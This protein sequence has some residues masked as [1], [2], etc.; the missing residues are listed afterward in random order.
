MKRILPLLAFA[1]SFIEVRSDD[2]WTGA[3]DGNWNTAGNWLDGSVPA[4]SQA[5][6]NTVTIGSAG[7]T[8]FTMNHNRASGNSI[9]GLIINGNATSDIVLGGNALGFGAGGID[10]S[11]STVDVTFN[12]IVNINAGGGIWNV[13]AGRMLTLVDVNNGSG[14]TT[15]G[16]GTIR[17]S[18]SA[19]NA[20][21]VM[22]VGGTTTLELAKASSPGNHT[23]GSAGTGLTV[24]SGASVRITG[25]GGEQIYS[26][27]DVTVNTGGTFDFNGQ[28]EGWDG[29]NGGGLI[30]NTAA[31]DVILTLGQNNA[32]GTFT[33]TLQ[34]SGA[35]NLSLVKTGSGTLVLNN[36]GAGQLYTGTTTINNGMLQIRNNTNLGAA[37]GTLYMNGGGIV[38]VS[39]VSFAIPATRPVEVGASGGFFRLASNNADI[40]LSAAVTGVGGLRVVND[41][42]GRSLFVTNPANSYSGNT[43]IGGNS[44]VFGWNGTTAAA[45]MRLDANE[46]IPHG[47]GKGNLVFDPGTEGAEIQ[48]AFL[49]LNGNRT[50]TVNGLSA[51]GAGNSFIQNNTAGAGLLIIGDNNATASFNGVIRNN[52]GSGG[53]MAI[54]KMG[55]GTQTF[56]G[57]TA[58]TFTGL[59]TVNGGVLVFNKTAGLNAINGQ[60]T[61]GDGVG[62]DTARLGASNQLPDAATITFNSGAVF[63]LNGNVET[64]GTITSATGNGTIDN[65]SSTPGTLTVGAGT[66]GG[67]LTSSGG[68]ATHLNKTGAGVLELTAAGSTTQ[69]KTSVNGGILRVGTGNE[70]TLGA[71]PAA[72]A[73]DQFHLSSGTLHVTTAS[74]S[75]NDTN[76]GV[77]L[78]AGGGTF[79]VDGGISLTVN[80]A[81]SGAPGILTKT[82]AGTFNITGN[83]AAAAFVTAQGVYNQVSGTTT[84][85]GAAGLTVSSGATYS[86]ASGVLRTDAVNGAGTFNW[87]GEL[88]L[89]QAKAAVSPSGS[90]FTLAPAPSGVAVRTGTTLSG[91][92]A[93]AVLG[94][95]GAI[96]N[97]DGLYFSAGVITDRMQIA[98]SI[99]LSGTGDLLK[100]DAS[101]VY[102]LRP[103]GFFTEDYGSIPLVAANS[104]T[105]TFDTFSGLTDDGKGWT[106][107]AS[108]VGGVVFDPSTLNGNEGFIQ[109]ADNV[110]NPLG[111]APGTYDI[112]YFHY[113]VQGAVPEPDTFALIGLSVIGLRT[114]RLLRDRRARM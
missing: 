22:T 72:F 19:D 46:V 67:T 73:S 100:W 8:N 56:A 47:V 12:N 21:F 82:G 104:I 41:S 113:K 71:N 98:G 49:N 40:T 70:S 29:L 76:R 111:F 69:G 87:G 45:L 34:D 20:G 114:A 39:G 84:L 89:E 28:S 27:A 24:N 51:V 11:A 26:Q 109:Y 53:T 31:T 48:D 50:E 23:I 9:T 77:S 7:A 37:G 106:Q 85:N 112:I 44:A 95:N 79:N 93:T 1:A 61:I 13:P 33:G 63:D 43:T 62:T 4:N 86:L 83:A 75:L 3:V 30:D 32:G 57:T 88:A 35:G 17:L 10:M 99:D 25:S 97:L 64:V 101:T 103:F 15:A 60:L 52:S 108:V 102:L 14:V 96:L 91:T 18:G 6:G 110:V 66:Y 80:N 59:T 5:A 2:S 58:N 55:T 42:P 92:G 94:G 16:A 65:S 78:G 81:L 105:G 38:N 54:T 68:G 90:D 107:L 74:L 36:T